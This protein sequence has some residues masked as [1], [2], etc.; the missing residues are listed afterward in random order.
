MDRVGS[1]LPVAEFEKPT[2]ADRELPVRASGFASLLAGV[3]VLIASKDPMSKASV[4]QPEYIQFGVKSIDGIV[5]LVTPSQE[6]SAADVVDK[7]SLTDEELA[8]AA[9]KYDYGKGQPAEPIR[10]L[11][12]T[13]RNE[14]LAVNRAIADDFTSEKDIGARGAAEVFISTIKTMA[15]RELLPAGKYGDDAVRTSRLMQGEQA[16]GGRP[17]ARVKEYLFEVPQVV[18]GVEVFGAGTTVAVHRSGQLA[19]IKSVGPGVS[20]F[21]SQATMQRGV[22]AKS[23]EERARA[24][25]SEAVVTHVGLRYPWQATKDLAVAARPR[26]VFQVVP[27]T[28]VDG[29][30]IHGRGHF[31]FYSVESDKEAPLVWPTPNLEASGD[32]RK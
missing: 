19:S 23:L 6:E 2:F 13:T 24:E 1:Y 26:E 17:T 16:W 28:T 5:V 3:D 9:Q 4:S 15:E 32:A 18:Q 7:K 30:T 31:V 29:Q 12:N 8:A 20:P 27:V 25:Y 14:M 21:A 10:V 11:V 22:S